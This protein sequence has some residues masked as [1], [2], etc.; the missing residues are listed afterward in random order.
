VITYPALFATA[1]DELLRR[2]SSIAYAGQPGYLRSN[3]QQGV[4]RLPIHW[5]RRS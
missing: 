2:T 5:R 4:K 3:F 1:V